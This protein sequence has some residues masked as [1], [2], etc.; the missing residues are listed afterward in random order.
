MA[1]NFNAIEEGILNQFLLYSLSK[2]TAVF[3]LNDFC[4]DFKSNLHNVSKETL[5]GSIRRSKFLFK[6]I[7]FNGET[8]IELNTKVG[9]L[10]YLKSQI[11]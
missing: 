8:V 10:E 7:D 3:K 5:L 1:S 4:D 11:L 2:N 6:T 9:F